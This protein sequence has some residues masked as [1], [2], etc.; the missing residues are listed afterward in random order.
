MQAIANNGRAEGGGQGEACR[1]FSNGV[2]AYVKVSRRETA[3]HPLK[4]VLSPW[5]REELR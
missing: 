2:S 1:A 5:I 3:E 4:R